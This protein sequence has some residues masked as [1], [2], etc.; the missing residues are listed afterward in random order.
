M[1]V[2]REISVECFIEVFVENYLKLL[3]VKYANSEM[4]EIHK[5]IMALL[6]DEILHVQNIKD[7]KEKYD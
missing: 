1:E 2:M 6:I 4:S 7:F 3:P 5:R